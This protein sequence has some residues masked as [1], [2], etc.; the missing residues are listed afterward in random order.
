MLGALAIRAV[1]CLAERFRHRCALPT[2]HAVLTDALGFRIHSTCRDIAATVFLEPDRLAAGS[3]SRLFCFLE[4]YSSRQRIAHLRIGPH[5]EL[6]LPQPHVI[7][8]RLAAGQAAVYVLP[9]AA[10]STLPPGEHDIPVTLKVHKPT[11]TG[12][13]LPGTR[14]HLYDLWTIHFAAPFTITET[15]AGPVSASEPSPPEAARFLTLA[16]VSEKE[17][18]F[19]ALEAMVTS[20]TSDQHSS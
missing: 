11:G 9:L 16:S 5:H 8:L 14:R 18:H 2:S 13:R 19:D 20:G 12:V 4:N 10:A 7:A 6:G 15:S 3:S 17:S 1:W